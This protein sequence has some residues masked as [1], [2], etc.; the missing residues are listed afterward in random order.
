MSPGGTWRKNT[1]SRHATRITPPP[2]T[3]GER[4][5]LEGEYYSD[6][7]HVLYTVDVEDGGIV[8]HHSHGDVPMAPFGKDSFVG[9]WPFGLVRFQCPPRGACTGFSATEDR[10]RDVPFA[11]VAIR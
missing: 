6:E 7:L 8:L 5:A 3:D 4:K 9:P 1:R 2:I 11:R 10:A